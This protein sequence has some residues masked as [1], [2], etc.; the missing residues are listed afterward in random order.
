MT[1]AQEHEAYS[2]IE[3]WLEN[4]SAPLIVDDGEQAEAT[5]PMH[6]N[7]CRRVINKLQQLPGQIRLAQGAE[8]VASNIWVLAAS[9]GGIEA[10]REFF[11]ALPADLP[12]GFLYVQHIDA[13]HEAPLQDMINRCSHYPAYKVY[14]GGVIQDR[15][16]AIL[17]GCKWVDCQPNGTLSVRKEQWPGP[18]SPSINQVFANCALSFG[19]RCGAI[20][21]SGMG[22]DGTTGARLILQRGGQVWAQEPLSCAIDSMPQAAITAGVVSKIAEPKVLAQQLTERLKTY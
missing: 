6:L 13:G 10:V 9:T 8:V 20:L 14:H 3:Q 15:S 1:V 16:T 11:Q 5:S 22:D 12:V 21:F 18:Y 17:A 7:W 19:A 2:Q 4:S